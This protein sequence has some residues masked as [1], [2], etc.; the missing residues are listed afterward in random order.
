[1]RE[2]PKSLRAYFILVGSVTLLSTLV[3]LATGFE[4]LLAAQP[5]LILLMLLSGVMGAAYLYVGVKLP[6]LL[7]DKPQLPTKFATA[8]IILSVLSLSLLGALINIYILYQLKRMAK[9]A[10]PEMEGQVLE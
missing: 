6:T 2:T 4:T 3:T 8:A 1:M 5:Y 7:R 9:E 10:A